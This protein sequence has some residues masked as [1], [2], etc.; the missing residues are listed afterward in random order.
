[1]QLPVAPTVVHGFAVVN[2]PGPLSFVKLIDVPSGAF[3]KPLPSPAFTFTCAVK[4]W[5]VPTGFESVIG[6][7]WMFASTNVL[8]AS[9]ELPAR[10]LV[11]TVNAHSR[12]STA[13]RSREPVTLPAVGEMNVIV[14]WTW[15]SVFV[16]AAAQVPV[17]A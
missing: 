3:T 6:V 2:E 7:I 1:M 16:A 12:R 11:W 4:T 14:H 10:P 17:G 13:S 5:S 9:T 8:T 15:P